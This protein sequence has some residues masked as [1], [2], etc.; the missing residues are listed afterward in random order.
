MCKTKEALNDGRPSDWTLCVER[1][2]QK[3]MSVD[4]MEKLSV[5]LD[6]DALWIY[7]KGE[8]YKDCT[9]A[10]QKKEWRVGRGGG[11]TIPEKTVRQLYRPTVGSSLPPG[12]IGR[13]I[14]KAVDKLYATSPAGP[15]IFITTALNNR[16]KYGPCVAGVPSDMW[17][18]ACDFTCAEQ[19]C[20]VVMINVNGL[21]PDE[22]AAVVK[23]YTDMRRT[24][25]GLTPDPDTVPE[26]E[27]IE[28][29]EELVEE[30]EGEEDPQTPIQHPTETTTV[31][32]PE[33]EPVP[34]TPVVEQLP[35][36]APE[37]V[38]VPVPDPPVKAPSSMSVVNL[39]AEAEAKKYRPIKQFMVP[40]NKIG[41]AATVPPKSGLPIPRPPPPPKVVKAPKAGAPSPKLAQDTKGDFPDDSDPIVTPEPAEPPPA[42]PEEDDIAELQAVLESELMQDTPPPQQPAKDTPAPSEEPVVDKETEAEADVDEEESEKPTTATKKKVPEKKKGKGKGKGKPKDSPAESKKKR[43]APSAAEAETAVEEQ[44]QEQEE[45]K[46]APLITPEQQQEVIDAA[47]DMF[48][49]WQEVLALADPEGASYMIDNVTHVLKGSHV[50]GKGTI[51]GVTMPPYAKI[52]CIV[53][54]GEAVAIDASA[55]GAPSKKKARTS[56]KAPPSKKKGAKATTRPAKKSA[57][58][59]KS[60]KAKTATTEPEPEPEPETGVSPWLRG[61]LVALERASKETQEAV[62][63][64]RDILNAIRAQCSAETTA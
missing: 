28:A 26:T 39:A 10:G 47:C 20:A 16:E 5:T 40:K 55:S 57:T 32:E 53:P 11:L 25:L 33:P 64:V 9:D 38:Q 62:V 60:K 22:R 52:G 27:V 37:P 13:T 21:P 50:Y 44:E 31:L 19:G 45:K 3:E 56:P 24:V 63:E 54:P 2:K 43:K 7:L 35:V 34:V 29:D 41:K 59:S 8:F 18:S 14:E 30:G 48:Q 36:P 51:Q 49:A 17:N 12:F 61:R 1:C 42:S 23:K 6:P 15:L 58:P 4:P 46:D